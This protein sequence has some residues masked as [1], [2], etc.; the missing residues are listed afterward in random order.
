MVSASITV[1]QSAAA[2]TRLSPDQSSWIHTGIVLASVPAQREA[3][4]STAREPW[5]RTNCAE[6]CAAEAHQFLQGVHES[7]PR[8][9]IGLPAHVKARTVKSL[10]SVGLME[11]KLGASLSS[12]PPQAQCGFGRGVLLL[13]RSPGLCLRPPGKVRFA[14]GG[15]PIRTCA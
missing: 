4:T 13:A 2:S 12:T 1:V 15:G 11:L 5:N 8:V 10:F 3:G 6:S 7:E 14:K 9:L